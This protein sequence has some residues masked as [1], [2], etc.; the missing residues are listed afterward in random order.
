MDAN[1]SNL[2]LLLKAGADVFSLVEGRTCLV[3]AIEEGHVDVV[4]ILLK[5]GGQKLLLTRD[6]VSV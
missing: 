6:V 2:E 3:F 4:Q 5:K 1:I